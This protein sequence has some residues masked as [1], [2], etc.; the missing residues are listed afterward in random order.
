[1]S[2]R[3]APPAKHRALLMVTLLAASAGLAF[4]GRL[5]LDWLIAAYPDEAGAIERIGG[6]ILGMAIGL[7]VVIPVYK[8]YGVFDDKHESGRPKR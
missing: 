3:H 2:D 4:V 5:G 7:L 1:M 6:G 8:M